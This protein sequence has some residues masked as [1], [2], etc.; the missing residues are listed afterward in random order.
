MSWLGLSER[1]PS[2]WVRGPY[3]SDA[4]VERIRQAFPDLIIGTDLAYE[5]VYF[6]KLLKSLL[7]LSTEGTR[8]IL[9]QRHRREF[10]EV[11]SPIELC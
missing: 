7:D 2:S 4:I 3:V 5:S 10:S 11:S 6:S 9:G 8:W 1:S